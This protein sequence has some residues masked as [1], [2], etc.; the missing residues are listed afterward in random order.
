MGWRPRVHFDKTR[1]YF[2]CRL[3]RKKHY[4]GKDF[5]KAHEQFAKL[6][7]DAYPLPE[8][9]TV[10]EA[11]EGW[12]R[13]NPGD[14]RKTILK[15][16]YDF[17][18]TDGL[19]GLPPDALEQYARHLQSK[20]QSARTI[21]HKINHAARVCRWAV[22]HGHMQREP[23]RPKVPKPMQEPRDVPM[24]KLAEVFADLPKQAERILA[25]ILMTGARPNEARSLK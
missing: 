10:A 7:G 15:A 6:L 12:L 16:W 3:R 5:K 14:W 24:P 8:P 1:K 19:D 23:K 13:E 17:A 20:K 25:F 11:I 21:K 18:G 2:Y 4:L 22:E 9:V